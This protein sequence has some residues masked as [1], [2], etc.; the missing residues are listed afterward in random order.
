MTDWNKEFHGISINCEEKLI[1][2]KN[3]GALLSFLDDP[4]T[5]GSLLVSEYAHQ[6]YLKEMGRPLNISIDSVAIEILGH[7]YADKFADLASRFKIKALQSKL[8]DIK[9]RTDIIDCGERDIDSDRHIWDDL[10][11]HN[12][13]PVIFA[14]CGKRA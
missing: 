10:D 3:D 9:S 8:A 14:M 6:L 11:K 2:I 12:L 13:K 4:A 7:V 1:Q 5:K